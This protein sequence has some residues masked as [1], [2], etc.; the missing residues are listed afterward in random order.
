MSDK[1]K[2]VMGMKLREKKGPFALWV[3]LLAFLLSLVCAGMMLAFFL[4]STPEEPEEKEDVYEFA[5]LDAVA[6]IPGLW[7]LPVMKIPV[8]VEEGIRLPLRL[9]IAIVAEE[10][11][12]GLPRLLRHRERIITAIREHVEKGRAEDWESVAGKLKL[13]YELTDLVEKASGGIRV[14]G[15]YITDYMIHWPT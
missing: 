3:W 7:Q 4:F 1:K 8:T 5:V 14:K 6:V 11:P 13:K 2:N 12:E 15:L 9:G 10:G